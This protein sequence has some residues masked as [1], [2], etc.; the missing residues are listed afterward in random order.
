[1]LK[2]KLPVF[3]K[4]QQAIYHEIFSVVISQILQWRKGEEEW[5][6]GKLK[7]ENK[8]NWRIISRHWKRVVEEAYGLIQLT[9]RSNTYFD[10]RNAVLQ[11]LR[12]C[13]RTLNVQQ[14]KL[15]YRIKTVTGALDIYCVWSSPELAHIYPYYQFSSSDT[16]VW[17]PACLMGVKWSKWAIWVMGEKINLE[18]WNVD[19]IEHDEKKR[20]EEGF[21]RRKVME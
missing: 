4:L 19:P 15:Y 9:Q 13:S 18:M 20:E 5:I 10:G 16:R 1:M 12:V 6:I 14:L 17:T 21:E 2:I 7:W 8:V 3:V 11:L